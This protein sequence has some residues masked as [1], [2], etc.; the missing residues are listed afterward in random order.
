M[1]V[2]FRTDAS[3]GIGTGH[4]MRCLTL[5][6]LLA[7]G[8]AQCRFVCRQ[9]EGH[10]VDYIR[11]EGFD[12]RGL[13]AGA[14][15][16][17][18]PSALAHAQWVGASQ[19]DDAA[20]T[21]E[22]LRDFSA[23][24]LVVDHYG[25]DQEWESR[26][27]SSAARLLAIDDLADR[28]HVCNLL[29]D[30]TLGRDPDDYRPLVP[31]DCVVLAGPEYALLRPEFAQARQDSL[32]RRRAAGSI[33]RVLVTLGGV[34][35]HN[36]TEAVLKVLDEEGTLPDACQ[37]TVVMGAAAPWLDAVKARASSMRR[38]TEV[39]LNVRDM[40]RRMADSDLAIGAAGSTSW[41]R[42]CLG[43]PTALL[44]LAENQLPSAQALGEAGAV[45]LIG[46]P[47][48]IAQRLPGILAEFSDARV[49]HA[50]SDMASR[51]CDG[52]GAA[53]VAG[54]MKERS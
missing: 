20:Q 5:A 37:I 43:L 27:Q 12:A 44:V 18:S 39:V 25:L 7:A 34:D 15:M 3:L 31:A 19:A 48:D 35:Q 13:P 40:A 33:G 2:A 14:A 36:A 41:E 10:L 11:A 42:C 53:R 8:G 47:P 52:L 28:R 1:K 45:R 51:V 23:D 17:P 32:Q 49:L 4:V 38:P 46:G 21:Y 6:R 16:P 22:Q 30:Q 9:H 29:L 54:L 24:W 26:L 50:A